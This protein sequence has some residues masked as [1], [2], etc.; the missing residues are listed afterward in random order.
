MI[1][2]K[3][4]GG[5]GNQ[6]FQ[7]A[8]ATIVAK[9][10]ASK[11]LLE[12]SSFSCYKKHGYSPRTF[13]LSIF[14]NKY[15]FSVSNNLSL[16]TN[17]SLLD[18]FKKKIG[19]NYPKIFEESNLDY[20]EEANC[21][22]TPVYARGYFQTAKYYIGYEDVVKGLFKFEIDKL[23]KVNTDLIPILKNEGTIAVHIRRGD[24]IKDVKTNQF[25]GVCCIEYYEKAIAFV[26]SK[27]KNPTLV[28]FSDDMKWVKGNFKHLN[29]NTLYINHNKDKDNWM[30]MF[31]M[32]ICSHNIIANS[33][34]S[35][36]GAWLN[37]NP[38]KMVVAPKKWF[39]SEQ[40]IIHSI[41]PKEWIV[42]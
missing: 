14:N 5:L 11:V 31:L 26:T 6:M 33:S 1:L 32:H 17:L 15:N 28:F 3:L 23:S 36:W 34:F 35:W 7:Y 42:L 30:D 38:N 12:L 2:I 4:Q 25:H 20:S 8:F 16:F 40:E 27:I 18:C 19:L 9:K 41:I 21:L 39:Q 13:E 37:E 10:N 22:K 24:Y 29:Y